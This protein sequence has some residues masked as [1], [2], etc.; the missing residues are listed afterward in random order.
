[1]NNIKISS[2]LELVAP[3]PT[4]DAPFA[5]AWFDSPDGKDTLLKMGNAESEIETRT[6]EG[7]YSILEEFIRLEQDSKQITRMIRLK[8]RTIGAVWIGLEDTEH[9]K[10][11]ALHIMIGDPSSRGMGIGKVVMEAMLN[12]AQTQLHVNVVYSRHLTSNRVIAK[13][14]DYLGFQKDGNPYTEK[15]GQIFQNV[16]LNK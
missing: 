14:N 11:P 5:L 7:E 10:A 9:L 16:R 4:R 15:N 1:M 12:F 6:L 3:N 8:D 2:D 13:V